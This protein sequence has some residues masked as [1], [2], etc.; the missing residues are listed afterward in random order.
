MD[1]THRRAQPLL[2]DA[3]AV[4]SVE[5]ASVGDS[6]YTPEQVLQVLRRPEHYA[7]LAC[8]G[9]NPVGFLSCLETET[10]LGLCLE[11]DLLGVR[12][13]HRGKGIAT[14]LLRMAIGEAQSRG[15]HRFR[16]VVAADNAASQAAFTH[17]GLVAAQ[18]PALLLVYEILGYAAV[19]FL[20]PRWTW[21]I[22][23]C[24]V[25]SVAGWPPEAYRLLDE[26]GQAVS[27]GICQR[28]QTL[29]YCGLWIEELWADPGAMSVALRAIV[30]HAKDL[31]LDQVG[32]LAS[33]QPTED[34]LYSW[35]RL[36][37]R[38][39]GPYLVFTMG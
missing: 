33:G 4:L 15:T 38:N 18:D 27:Q 12:A 31:D 16:G 28:V 20:P 6:P 22:D 1:Y 24:Q 39:L 29:S 36:G 23:A 34:E 25:S 9:T 13:E 21:L 17:A 19:A 37:Y 32:H 8:E 5:Q 14:S 10:C 30:E 26:Q 7:Y 35:L 2:D 11:L 3:A